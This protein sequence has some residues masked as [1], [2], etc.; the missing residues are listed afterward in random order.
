VAQPPAAV[1][2]PA[3]QPRAA[4]PHALPPPLPVYR[5]KLDG[6]ETWV[7]V[8]A[9]TLR[10]GTIE[11]AEVQPLIDA[12]RAA[13]VVIRR[14]ELVRPS[15]EELFIETVATQTGGRRMG[16]GAALS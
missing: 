1:I 9:N 13:S 7:E 16:A 15:L 5:G 6:R 11:A 3:S 2:L 8:Q 12:L 10:V 4:V 14:V